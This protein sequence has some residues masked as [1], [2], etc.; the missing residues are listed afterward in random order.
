MKSYSTRKNLFILK[1]LGNLLLDLILFGPLNLVLLFV[2]AYLDISI[3]NLSLM[4]GILIFSYI[5]I[6]LTLISMEKGI[7][8][9][10]F[11]NARIIIKRDSIGGGPR[12]MEGR[13]KRID[14]EAVQLLVKHSDKS[15]HLEYIPI[16]SII[17]VE[18]IK[19]PK[20][21]GK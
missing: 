17:H 5:F 6:A 13:I 8:S 20:S 7:S 1:E 11:R 12:S 15:I 21:F 9:D 2:L 16:D 4:L 10:I 14:K 3:K 19:R 18:L